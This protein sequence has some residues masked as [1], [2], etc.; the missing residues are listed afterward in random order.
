MTKPV[1][2]L[3]HLLSRRG[4]LGHPWSTVT[5]PLPGTISFGGGIPDPATLPLPQLRVAIERALDD[6]DGVDALQYGGSYG[7]EGLREEIAGRIAQ[8]AGPRVSPEHVVITTGS[9]QALDLVCAA[10]IDPGDV[11]LVE[12]PT[13]P[14]SLWTFRAHGAVPW[15]V[16]IDRLG[17]DVEALGARLAEVRAEGRQ[18]KLIY[19]TPDF[20]N[21]T[22]TRL[23]PER[24]QRLVELAEA[25]DCIVVEDIAYLQIDYAPEPP[26]P[27]LF[28]LA[29][30]RVLQMGTFSKMIGPGLRIGWLVG[31]GVAIE[32]AARGRTDMGSSV[33]MSSILAQFLRDGA[34]EPH[35]GR[36]REVYR[37]KRDAMTRALA[38]TVGGL[39]TWDTPEGGFFLWLRLNDGIDVPALVEVARQERVGFVPGHRFLVEERPLPAL[40]LAFSQVSLE[41]IHEGVNRLGRSLERIG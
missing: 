12:E 24:R 16:P 19:L 29:P 14:G 13:F 11:V 25:Y 22:G 41:D 39:G 30:D 34:L 6:S 37:A 23:A 33:T 27:T 35:L 5:Q 21:H 15:P 17:I 9:S 28:A 8:G 26:P 31:P 38:E 36:V 3:Q 18:T 32:A 40:R 7:H 4:A 1:V 10:F 2:S 20:Q